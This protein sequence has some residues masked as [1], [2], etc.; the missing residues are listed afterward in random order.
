MLA[1]ADACRSKLSAESPRAHHGAMSVQAPRPFTPGRRWL[2]ETMFESDTRAGRG[3]DVV[4]LGLILLSLVSVSLESLESIHARHGAALWR[5][6]YALTAVFTLEYSA[7]LYAHPRPLVYARSFFGI[8][9]LLSILPT[10]VGLLVPGAQ[11][12]VVVR[13]LR[14]L[15]VFRILKLTRFVRESDVLRKALRASLPKILVFLIAILCTVT[16]CGATMHLIEGPESKF[17]SI[18]I[19]IYWAI[20]TLTTV[21]YGDVVPTTTAGHFVASMI[22]VLGY[23][24]IAVPTGIISAELGRAPRPVSGQHCSRCG[25][26]GHDADARHCKRCGASLAE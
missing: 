3:F 10:W 7:R 19:G 22:M 23:G 12:F 11:A 9:D 25:L 16:I 2:Y 26:E 13:S 18:P 17:S 5:I 4:L 8:V 6:E 21:G 20:V 15:R 14:L 1:A 24:V